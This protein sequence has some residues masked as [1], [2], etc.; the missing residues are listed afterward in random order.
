MQRYFSYFYGLNQVCLDKYLF[1]SLSKLFVRVLK[2][3]DKYKRINVLFIVLKAKN[4]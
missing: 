1:H 2:Y 3:S 4:S